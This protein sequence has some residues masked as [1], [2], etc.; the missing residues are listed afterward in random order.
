MYGEK[1]VKELVYVSRKAGKSKICRVGCILQTQRRANVEVQIR[2]L[3]V[4]RIY[5]CMGEVSLLFYSGLPIDWMRPADIG[6]GGWENNLIYSKST[7]LNIN[8]I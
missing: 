8:Y 1:R 7:D 2:R 5:S 4:G 3:S 6:V